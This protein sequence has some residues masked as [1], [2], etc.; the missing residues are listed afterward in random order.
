MAKFAGRRGDL[1]WGVYDFPVTRTQK[2]ALDALWFI[3]GGGG[4]YS[5]LPA[6]GFYS[7]TESDGTVIIGLNHRSVNVHRDGRV[8]SNRK[9]ALVAL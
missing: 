8:T 5:V 1:K 2:A 3:M 6:D 4:T 9:E 7:Q